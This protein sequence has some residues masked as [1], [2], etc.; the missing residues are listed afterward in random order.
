MVGEALRKNFA[1]PMLKQSNDSC[2]QEAKNS[3]QYARFCG[4]LNWYIK[5]KYFSLPDHQLAENLFFF[6]ISTK[7]QT[8][9]K[10]EFVTKIVGTILTIIFL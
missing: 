4:L 3:R 2:L 9:D 5:Q 7:G 1:Y 8:R 6:F 10:S